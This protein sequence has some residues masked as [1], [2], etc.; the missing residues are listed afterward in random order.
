MLDGGELKIECYDICVVTQCKGRIRN[1]IFGMK[2][3]VAPIVE[4]M[5]VVLGDLGIRGEDL[6]NP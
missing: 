3:G 5:R 2:L 6:L 4:K 1:N